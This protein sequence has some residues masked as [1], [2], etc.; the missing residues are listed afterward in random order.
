MIY[1]VMRNENDGG[2]YDVVPID[3]V[4]ANSIDIIREYVCEI[5]DKA[6]ERR[7]TDPEGAIQQRELL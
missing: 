2:H 1:A 7:E 6:I 5:W 4:M 3:F